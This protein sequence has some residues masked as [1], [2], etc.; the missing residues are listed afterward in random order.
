[1]SPQRPVFVLDASLG[2]K[3]FKPEPDQAAALALL[4][5]ATRG[6]IALAAPAHF[7]HEVL[8]VVGHHYTP[9]DIVPAWERLKASG[10]AVLPLSDEVVAE[11]ARQCDA[12]GCSF[13]DALA[14][15]CAS[16]LGATLASADERAHGAYPGVHLIPGPA[17]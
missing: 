17:S 6:E 13:Y 7:V 4:D 9:R 10:I 8:S 15:A 3:W 14:P 16:L 5:R 11:A 12:L 1:M 2:V